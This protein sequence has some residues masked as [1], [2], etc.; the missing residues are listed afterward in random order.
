MT[1]RQI[2]TVTILIGLF[3]CQNMKNKNPKI[4][5]GYFF[6]VEWNTYWD[7]QNIHEL[8]YFSSKDSLS[9]ITR[10]AED[11]IKSFTKYKIDKLDAD[12]IFSLAYL[13]NKK[14]DISDTSMVYITDSENISIMCEANNLSF[15]NSYISQ[16]GYSPTKEIGHIIS[17]IKRVTKD[18][19]L[20][21]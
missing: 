2:L 4:P 1:I 9:I 17:I 7:N 18:T 11:S 21:N 3:S 19:A 13:N 15:T 5:K 16:S 12:S 8:L 20:F 6:K 14:F 10:T